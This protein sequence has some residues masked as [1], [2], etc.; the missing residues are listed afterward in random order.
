MSRWGCDRQAS[1]PL[2]ESDGREP[3]RTP[4]PST[5]VVV[6]SATLLALLARRRGGN[7]QRVTLSMLGANAYANADDFIS[8]DGKPPRPSVDE[9]LYGF[10]PLYRLYPARSGWVF[11]GVTTDE[12]WKRFCGP[13]GEA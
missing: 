13:S 1:T 8:Y 6:A 7:G 10:G 9:H 3:D 12:E 5:S 11:L 4:D 2:V